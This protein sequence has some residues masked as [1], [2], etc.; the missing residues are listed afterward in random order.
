MSRKLNV[1]ARVKIKNALKLFAMKAA[2]ARKPRLEPMLIRWRQVLTVPTVRVKN[3]MQW[4]IRF[5]S[6][7]VPKQK[8][9]FSNISPAKR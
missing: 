9:I 7:V 5:R 8:T 1:P 4:A 2:I 3:W 6:S